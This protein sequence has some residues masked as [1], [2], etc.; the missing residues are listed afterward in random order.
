MYLLL[1]ILLIQSVSPAQNIAGT[2]GGTASS[3][4]LGLMHGLQLA[5]VHQNLRLPCN[6]GWAIMQSHPKHIFRP[7]SLTWHVHL[8]LIQTNLTKLVVIPTKLGWMSKWLGADI[9]HNKVLGRM[10]E[11]EDGRWRCC[12]RWERS[13]ARSAGEGAQPLIDHL[14]NDDGEDDHLHHNPCRR[15]MIF[16]T[17]CVT[18]KMA[19]DGREGWLWLSHGSVL[20][21]IEIL[22]AFPPLSDPTSVSSGSDCCWWWCS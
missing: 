22:I 5:S 12:D 13:P 15:M 21:P 18:I 16:A 3:L 17:T 19:G 1:S 7:G 10:A 2:K 6:L 20:S 11:W 14:I 4:A 8:W 9:D